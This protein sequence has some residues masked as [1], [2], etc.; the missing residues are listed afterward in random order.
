MFHVI[1]PLARFENIEKLVCLLEPHNIQWHV[2]TD[3]DNKVPIHFDKS[4]IHHY[5][6]PNESI[7]FWARSNNSINWFLETQDVQGDDY[8]C[9]LNDD[10]GYE[11]NFFQKL[12]TEIVQHNRPDLIITSMKRGYQIPEDLP[13]IKQHPTNTLI[14]APENMIVCGVGVEQFFLKGKL[15][16]QHRLPLTV[17]GDGEL[18]V[19]LVK[20]YSTVYL[21]HLYVLFNYL[22]P[23]RWVMKETIIATSEQT[24]ENKQP[25]KQTITTAPRSTPKQMPLRLQKHLRKK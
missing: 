18:I 4:W 24:I 25:S 11:N 9:V 3:D 22:E 23:G 14:A 5:I 2:I 8:Y 20:Q 1:T 10:D 12:K 16:K 19:E 6:C 13:P 21:P 7:E 15:F 17:Y